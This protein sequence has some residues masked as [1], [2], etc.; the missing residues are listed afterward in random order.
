MEIWVKRKEGYHHAGIYIGKGR[1]IHVW[2]E[3]VSALKHL[4]KKEP[5]VYVEETT[6]KKFQKDGK[7]I[8]GPTKASFNSTEII[9]RAL[10]QIGSPWAYDPLHWNC[11]H[12]SS[13]CVSGETVSLEADQIKEIFHIDL[14]E[15]SATFGESSSSSSE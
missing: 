1:I 5:I 9:S 11:Q 14:S 12:F 10:A 3:P 2:A 13:W 6:V 15:S 8:I 7:I 4:I